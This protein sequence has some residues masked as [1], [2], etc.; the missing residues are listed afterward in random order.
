VVNRIRTQ[1][2]VYYKKNK[3]DTYYDKVT[4]EASAPVYEFDDEV[5]D[6]IRQKGSISQEMKY[7]G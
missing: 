3:L 5:L 2:T 7:M 1:S 4:L 6:E